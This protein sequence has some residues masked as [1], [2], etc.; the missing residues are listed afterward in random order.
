ME[1]RTDDPRS[2]NDG[3]VAQSVR[4]VAAVKPGDWV[5]VQPSHDLP[6]GLR[7]GEP[8][9]GRVA[10]VTADHIDV[11]IGGALGAATVRYPPAALL[12]DEAP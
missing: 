3:S 11:L 2:V 12:L 8:T 9:R 7:G 6:P 10:A 4:G 1:A 5:Q